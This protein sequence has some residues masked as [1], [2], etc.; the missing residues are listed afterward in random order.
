MSKQAYIPPQ[1][2]VVT[3]RVE[4]GFQASGQ[5]LMQQLDLFNIMDEHYN[6]YGHENWTEAENGYF[7]SGW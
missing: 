4:Q 1:L 2:T 5:S 6:D 7:G 3:F